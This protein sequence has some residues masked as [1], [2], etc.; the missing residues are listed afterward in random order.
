MTFHLPIVELTMS[1]SSNSARMLSDSARS[2]ARLAERAAICAGGGG[3][4]VQLSEWFKREPRGV[5]WCGG[6]KMWG[7]SCCPPETRAACVQW[8]LARPTGVWGA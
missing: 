6:E 2:L 3:A 7:D 8:H 1:L 5:W 4:K